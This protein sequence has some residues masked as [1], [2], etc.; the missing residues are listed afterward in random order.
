MREFFHN[1][2][3]TEKSGVSSEYVNDYQK[4]RGRMGR[5]VL[6]GQLRGQSLVKN[7]STTSEPRNVLFPPLLVRPSFEPVGG[8]DMLLYNYLSISRLD[9]FSPFLFIFRGKRNVY[10]RVLFFSATN[11]NVNIVRTTL[12]F[13]Y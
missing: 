5:K 9:F 10:F 8:A 3:T 4:H 2:A 6:L 12:D 13:R 7:P 1:I 11:T